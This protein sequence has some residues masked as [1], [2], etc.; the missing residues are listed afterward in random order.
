MRAAGNAGP[1]PGARGGHKIDL[2]HPSVSMQGTGRPPDSAHLSTQMRSLVRAIV[3]PDSAVK[4]FE[5][6][7][8]FLA[9]WL[10]L[11]WPIP[12]FPAAC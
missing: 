10:R 9:L 4:R 12:T 8:G 3:L 11:S 5:N 7:S 1:A 6:T 2:A